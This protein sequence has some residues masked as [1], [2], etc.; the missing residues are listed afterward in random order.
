MADKVRLASPSD[1]PFQSAPFAKRRAFASRLQRIDLGTNVL[2]DDGA[3]QRV[4]IDIVD[5][6]WQQLA[7]LPGIAVENDNA[8]AGGAARQLD[9]PRFFSQSLCLSR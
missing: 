5:G 7:D 3:E 4:R 1:A 8:I 9:G 6:D 2:G